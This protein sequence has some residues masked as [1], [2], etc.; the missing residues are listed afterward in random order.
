MYILFSLTHKICPGTGSPDST[1]RS[2]VFRTP[3][4]SF[5]ILMLGFS[6]QDYCI[7]C[8][9]CRRPSFYI[10]ISGLRDERRASHSLL[11]KALLK[12]S[13]N[14]ST[15]NVLSRSQ[16]YY[17][18]I[19]FPVGQTKAFIISIH[20]SG[21]QCS[22]PKFLYVL[23]KKWKKNKSISGNWLFLPLFSILTI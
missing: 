8:K 15:Y 3:A 19:Q 10:Q 16:S 2:M 4:C 20:F 12:D 9:W 14:A 5:S 6:A 18:H 13:Q 22:S 11:W 21:R 7:V 17:S 23:L 1:C